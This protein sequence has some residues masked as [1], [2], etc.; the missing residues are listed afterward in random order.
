MNPPWEITIKQRTGNSPD[1]LTLATAQVLANA[2]GTALTAFVTYD[3]RLLECARDAGHP[4]S[5]PQARPHGDGWVVSGT[6]DGITCVVTLD[7]DGS[8][9]GGHLLSGEGVTTNP[10]A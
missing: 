6:R 1:P 9:S 7:K 3:R 4:Y 5:R 10:P 8:I 2:S